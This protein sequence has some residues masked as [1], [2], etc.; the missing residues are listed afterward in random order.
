M[1]I[2]MKDDEILKNQVYDC[3]FIRGFNGGGQMHCGYNTV[4]KEFPCYFLECGRNKK[5][6]FKKINGGEYE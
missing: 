5:C 2:F 3:P 1:S 4:H 6:T